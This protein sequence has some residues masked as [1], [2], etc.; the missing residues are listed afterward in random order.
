MFEWLND[1]WNSNVEKEAKRLLNEW[2]V[3]KYSNNG[4][5]MKIPQRR[6]DEEYNSIKDKLNNESYINQLY[7]QIYHIFKN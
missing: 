6:I 7:I 4:Y 2:S 1:I 3:E 5:L